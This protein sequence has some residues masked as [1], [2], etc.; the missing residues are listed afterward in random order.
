MGFENYSKLPGSLHSLMGISPP[1]VLTAAGM[2][3]AAP[4]PPVPDRVQVGRTGARCVCCAQ[5]MGDLFFF[6]LNGPGVRATLLCRNR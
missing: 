2:A 4:L 1:Q 5:E 6:E 3:T